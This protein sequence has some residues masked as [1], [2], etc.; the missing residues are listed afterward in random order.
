MK[1]SK[2]LQGMGI[3]G[4]IYFILFILF[5]PA[6]DTTMANSESIALNWKVVQNQLTPTVIQYFFEDTNGQRLTVKGFVNELKNSKPFRSLMNEAISSSP[7]KG[8]YFE[9]KPA[10]RDTLDDAYEFV[11]VESN[12]GYINANIGPFYDHL[13]NCQVNEVRNFLNLSGDAMLVSPCH[14]TDKEEQ[15]FCHLANFV[16]QANPVQRDNLWRIVG[17]EYEKKLESS[18]P[19]WLSTSGKGV[20]WLHMRLCDKPKYYTYSPYKS[21]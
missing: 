20:Y 4:V 7:F 15:V 14:D 3:C 9:S 1:C 12:F 21:F 6:P 10:S 18:E 17:E 2:V 16:R 13:K 19:T 5:S 11:L 8:L